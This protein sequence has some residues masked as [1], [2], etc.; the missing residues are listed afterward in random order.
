MILA[1]ETTEA[2]LEDK[3]VHTLLHLGIVYLGVGVGV[4][5]GC[6]DSCLDIA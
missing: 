1:P 2:H 4:G 3:H 5:V 6:R